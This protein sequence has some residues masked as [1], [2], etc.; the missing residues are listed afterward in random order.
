MLKTGNIRILRT[1]LTVGLAMYREGDIV[2]PR[3]HTHALVDLANG[4]LHVGHRWA[5]WETSEAAKPVSQP[6]PAAPAPESTPAADVQPAEADLVEAIKAKVREGK[7]KT[8][9]V[10]ELA[11]GPD[12][13][14]RQVLAVFDELLA[15]GQVVSTG[16]PGAYRV[17]G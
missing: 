8:A 2:A 14:Q 17:E 4:K 12:I 7:G 11:A 13:S 9:I 3:E 1:G 5:E 6:E 16:E 15:T 10:K